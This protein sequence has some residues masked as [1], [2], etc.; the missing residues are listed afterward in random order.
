MLSVW[1]YKGTPSSNRTAHV[2]SHDTTNLEPQTKLSAALRQP[3]APGPHFVASP[4]RSI[5]AFFVL[6]W[7]CLGPA[8]S[9]R[10]AARAALR[11][12]H[13]RRNSS[14][15]WVPLTLAFKEVPK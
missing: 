2:Q 12:L 7:L 11:A 14:A 6:T 4:R 13:G 9:A 15:Q 5:D 10:L 3:P 8:F 1:Q